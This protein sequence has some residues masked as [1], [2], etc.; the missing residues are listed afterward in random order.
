MSAR[1]QLA[2]LLASY[3]DGGV[4]RSLVRLAGGLAATG[5]GVDL[6]LTRHE[7][8]YLE[9]LHPAVQRVDLRRFDAT[10]ATALA[11]YL[12]ARRPAVLLSSKE[13]N[14]ALAAGV[15]A[16][17]AE[18]GTRIAMRLAT[19]FLARAEGRRLWPWQRRRAFARLRARYARADLLL[20]ISHD[21]AVQMAGLLEVPAA[22]IAVVR[23]PAFDP[24]IL[25]RAAGPAPHPWLAD[26]AVPVVLGIGGLRRQKDFPTLLRAFARLRRGRPAR[27]LILGRGR[28]AA[29]LQRLARRLRV[30]PDVALAG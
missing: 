12:R 22:R 29:R 28:Q 23:N 18:T 25:T 15:Q 13:Q 4:E 21:L 17:A 3:G 11:G 27:L 19:N 16:I 20:A 1:P 10:P 7:G 30:A 2:I 5:V 24:A 9:Q 6:L 8:P 26:P 14:D